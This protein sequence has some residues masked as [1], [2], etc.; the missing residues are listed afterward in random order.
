[1]PPTAK[2]EIPLQMQG[3][4]RSW[5]GFRTIVLSPELTAVAGTVAVF[6]FFAWNAG[7]NGFLTFLGTRNYLDVAATIGIVAIPVTL[8]LIAGEFDLSVG[9]TIGATGIAI[10]YPIV[11]LGWP[12]WA[13]LLC[14]AALAAAVGLANGLVVVRMGIPSFLV[15]LAS[16]FIIKG[17]A[18]AVTLLA[19]DASQIF[20][21]KS[22][23]KGDP[24]L[25]LF[26]GSI[27]GFHTSLAWWIALT[28]VAAYVLGNTRFG[29]WIYAS[30]GDREAALKMGVP[31]G[32]VKI[33]LYMLTSLSSAL[34]ATLSMMVVDQAEVI[35]GAGKEFEAVT[36][37]VIG[38][39]AITGGFGSPIGTFFGALMFGMVSQGFFYT[40][41]DDNWFYAFVGGI[42]LLAVA[43][44]KYVR[45]AAMRPGRGR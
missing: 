38:G 13:S 3:R 30:G 1:M 20:R 16:M 26:S 8:L 33:S 31:V 37:A 27:F 9:V 19:V 28:V 21:V 14:G 22:T 7:D 32:R 12:L 39:A 43:V 40:D 6:L 35:Q 17:V 42:L 10:A 4:R 29:N 24:L 36:A 23:L 11:F 34:V 2:A 41:I 45:Q 5:G 15:T 44:N 18:L 25:P